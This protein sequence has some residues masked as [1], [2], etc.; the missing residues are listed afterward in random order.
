MRITW[1]AQP[2]R[3]AARQIQQLVGAPLGYGPGAAY[4]A[5]RLSPNHK[6]VAGDADSDRL[7]QLLRQFPQSGSISSSSCATSSSSAKTRRASERRAMCVANTGSLRPA[8]SSR[9]AAQLCITCIQA[10]FRAGGAQRASS[11]TRKP[12]QPPAKTGA[13]FGREFG[14]RHVLG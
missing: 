12:A 5:L 6:Q 8:L 11:A 13:T 14:R 1:N 3:G 2:F 9:L 10:R 7:V 4:L